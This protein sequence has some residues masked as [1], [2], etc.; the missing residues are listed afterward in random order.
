MKFF[1]PDSKF[2]QVMT[3][4][5]E[6]MMLN[7]CWII[8]SIPII[9][10]GAS[11]IAM[12]TV[13]RRRL[14]KESSGTM[15]PLLS[16]RRR[17]NIKQGIAFWLAQLLI[18]ASLGLSMFLTLPTFFK[19]ISL[20]VL[21]L[22]SLTFSIIYPQIA[23]FRNNWFAYLK[24]ALVLLIP[25][26]GW[27]LLNMLMFLIPVGVFLVSPPFFLRLGWVWILFGFSVLFYLSSII[28]QKVLKPMEDLS[29]H[30]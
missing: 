28:M 7:L 9:T 27:A 3:S 20:I 21:I 14:R 30:R 8:A 26:L 11:N 1:S 12:Y 6:M 16:L 13:M 4:I 17:R 18:S 15:V 2:A 22:V 24:N 19:V 5:G 29:S 10:I 23:R 25:K